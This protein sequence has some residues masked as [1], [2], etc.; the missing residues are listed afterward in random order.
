MFAD[1]AAIE[2]RAERVAKAA[3][4]GEKAATA[5][6]EAL[7]R[8][9]AWLEDGKPARTCPVEIPATVDL[10]TAKPTLYVA[11]VDEG[12]EAEQ[13]EALRAFAQER[14]TECI[15]LN[16]KIEAELRE[17][18]DADARGV[19]GRPRHRAAGARPGHARGLPPAR[20][21]PVLHDRAQGDAGVD[22]PPRR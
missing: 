5:E 15:P 2:R 8:L 1:L 14:G 16:A 4:G 19:P 10:L 13:V 11:N 21:D 12:G 20:P 22:D 7:E 6:H 3:K 18:P 9:R 17:L